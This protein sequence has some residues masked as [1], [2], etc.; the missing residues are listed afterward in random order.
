MVDAA[1]APWRRAAEVGLSFRPI[2]ES[3]LPFLKR[4]YFSTRLDELAHIPWSDAQKTAFLD[5]QF[6]AQH[7]DY[8]ANYAQ[9]SWLVVLRGDEPIGRLYLDRW[10]REYRVI[11]IAFLPAHRGKGYGAALMQDLIAE[12]A[13]AGKA[14]SIHVEK[15]NPAR[16]LY[17]RLGFDTVAEHGVYDRL[18]RPMGAPQVKMA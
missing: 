10:A 4:V 14:V 18:E 9:A 8:Q 6:N 3:D 11:D 12:A 5:M 15:N 13:A 1:A 2:G 17:A 16:R 7:K